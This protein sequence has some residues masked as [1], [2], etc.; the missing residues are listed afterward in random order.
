MP[1]FR[2]SDGAADKGALTLNVDAFGDIEGDE[3]RHLYTF[4]A[5][6]GQEVTLRLVTGGAGL[7]GSGF[8]APFATVY[9][10][11]GSLVLGLD[12]RQ[13]SRREKLTLAEPGDYQIVVGPNEGIGIEGYTLT[14]EGEEPAPAP[15]AVP[16]PVDEPDFRLSPDGASDKGALTLDEDT[17]NE[18]ESDD[19]RHLYTVQATA[20]QEVRLRLVTGGAGLSG[21]G[22]Y[23]PFATIYAPDGSLALGL[24]SRQRSRRE[25][26]TFAMT[27][28]YQIVVGS[29][30]GYGIEGYTITIETVDG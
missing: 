1:D 2:L 24:D 21:S 5:T 7:S 20:G 29:Y 4:T 9:A 30:E 15:T 22:F 19:D 28:D 26:L 27:G 12:K 6:A 8:Y 17:F 16:I 3:D 23:A 14:I 13:R 11:D 25:I 10:P 18:I